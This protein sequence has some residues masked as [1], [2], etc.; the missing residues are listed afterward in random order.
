MHAREVYYRAHSMDKPGG[1]SLA[2]TKC[3]HTRGVH[4]RHPQLPAPA[5]EFLGRVRSESE[6]TTHE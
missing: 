3:G 2:P 4:A 1:G 6:R 5:G